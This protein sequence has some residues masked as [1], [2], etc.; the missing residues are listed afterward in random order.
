MPKKIQIAIKEELDFLE[1]SLA[2]TSSSLK[3]DRIRALL[4]IKKGKYV[5]YSDI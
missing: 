4:F 3:Q 1:K 5:F 2:K